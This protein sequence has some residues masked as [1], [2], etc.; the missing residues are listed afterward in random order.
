M[1][2][3]FYLFVVVLLF[4]GCNTEKETPA[5]EKENPSVADEE[6]VVISLGSKFT[7]REEPLNDWTRAGGSNDLYGFQVWANE[8]GTEAFGDPKCS[9]TGNRATPVCC[10]VFDN[11]EDIKIELSTKQ[12]Y[13]IEMVYVPNGKNIAYRHSSG[14]YEAPVNM[15]Y[16]TS[17]PLN[18]V[19]YTK[20]YLYQLG[21]S[22][23]NSMGNNN[24]YDV[25]FK[26]NVWADDTKCD[27]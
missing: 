15:F 26:P 23:I 25:N 9:D 16:W 4:M 6:T 12:T 13:N 2:K 17:T 18:S 3:Y 1:K 14:S 21:Q 11:L 27:F 20:D 10:G 7:V 22:G 8:K 5:T 24:R 19:L